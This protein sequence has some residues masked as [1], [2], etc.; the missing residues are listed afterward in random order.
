MAGL[1]GL[2]FACA[3]LAAVTALP[4]EHGV[5]VEQLSAQERLEA[6][7]QQMAQAAAF[8]RAILKAQEAFH[9]R[10]QMG[11]SMAK[12]AGHTRAAE[13]VRAPAK[14][15]APAVRQKVPQ[16]AAEQKAPAK[17][18][19]KQRKQDKEDKQQTHKKQASPIAGKKA[20]S[21]ANNKAQ[22]AAKRAAK[23]TAKRTAKQAKA[24]ESKMENAV[25][26]AQEAMASE[27]RAIH[28]QLLKVGHNSAVEKKEGLELLR[29]SKRLAKDMKELGKLIPDVAALSAQHKDLG[30]ILLRHPKRIAEAAATATKELRSLVNDASKDIR[31]E[32]AAKKWI[33]R[34]EHEAGHVL[35]VLHHSRGP[36]H[37]VK[38]MVADE[39]QLP[40]TVDNDVRT[41]ILDIK[42]VEDLRE[43][44][45]SAAQ[46][47]HEEAEQEGFAEAKNMQSTIVLEQQAAKLQ[48][49]VDA[50]RQKAKQLG[51]QQEA[52][53]AAASALP[54]LTNSKESAVAASKDLLKAAEA[55][56]KQL[57]GPSGSFKEFRT[58]LGESEGDAEQVLRMIKDFSK[59]V[60]TMSAETDGMVA[61]AE[62]KP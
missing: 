24:R 40:K 37:L 19:R 20:P 47:G 54:S 11:E 50:Q 34:Y 18:K 2:A 60:H 13:V 1:S 26:S 55:K 10:A 45:K 16:P 57:A 49:V 22:R 35:K 3:I 12:P 6:Q 48:R 62:G 61:R 38:Q 41:K 31:A 15:A 51:K 58:T 25:G 23:R 59:R 39:K 7:A 4:I 53:K 42:E 46:H 52:K 27:K 56:Q 21:V 44:L 30:E 43:E 17:S 9:Q 14:V 32:S 28:H 33:D 5:E 36:S 8:Q 29:R